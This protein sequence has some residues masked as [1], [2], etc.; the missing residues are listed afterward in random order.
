[1]SRSPVQHLFVLNAFGEWF[2]VPHG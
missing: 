1:V 2:W